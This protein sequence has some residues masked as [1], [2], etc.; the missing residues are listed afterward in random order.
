MPY[1]RRSATCRTAN[2]VVQKWD[3]AAY[4]LKLLQLRVQ[5][6]YNCNASVAA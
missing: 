2:V 1:I 4:E 3:F 5:A 6:K